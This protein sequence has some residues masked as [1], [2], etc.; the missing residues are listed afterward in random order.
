M[1][2]RWIIWIVLLS[3]FITT[4]SYGWV[5]ETETPDRTNWVTPLTTPELST[6]NPEQVGV[7]REPGSQFELANPKEL[8]NPAELEFR[9]EHMNYILEKH[10]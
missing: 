7:V 6:Q 1:S 3:L 2:L 8:Q 9:L 10:L 4:P 5:S